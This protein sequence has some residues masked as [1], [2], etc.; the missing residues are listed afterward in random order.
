MGGTMDIHILIAGS[1]SNLL[2]AAMV[3]IKIDS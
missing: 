3:S 2:W 1:D